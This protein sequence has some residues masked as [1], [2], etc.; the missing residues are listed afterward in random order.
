MSDTPTFTPGQSVTYLQ[1]LGGRRGRRNN[2]CAGLSLS[3][4]AKVV[5][6]GPK[7]VT[8][9]VKGEAE[10]RRVKARNLKAAQEMR[11]A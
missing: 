8:I 9:Q 1:P 2:F 6:V 11:N 5:S 4:P 3:V 10:T 7:L